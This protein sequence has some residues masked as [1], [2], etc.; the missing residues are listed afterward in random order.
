LVGS[1]QALE[2]S[3]L[4]RLLLAAA[5]PQTRVPH[6]KLGN[7]PLR[8]SETA[9]AAPGGF[10]PDMQRRNIMNLITWG[11]AGTIALFLVG[12]YATLFVPSKPDLSK[13]IPAE[14]K[15]GNNVNLKKW[16]AGHEQNTRQLVKG[17]NGDPQY[18]IMK[19]GENVKELEDFSVNAVCTHLGCTVPWNDMFGKYMCPC[20]GSQYDYNGKVIRGPAPLS[21]AISHV[22]EVDGDVR[23]FEWKEQDFR[24][25]LDPWW[26]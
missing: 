19:P 2:E 15:L 1:C 26:K 6:S 10:V 24:T 13:G 17:I 8:R 20:H 5:P 14:D 23:F 21:L 9:M 4:A 11:Q 22:A 25:G 3:D 7:S 12:N 16:L 18:L